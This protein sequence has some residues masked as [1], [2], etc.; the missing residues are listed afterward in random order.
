MKTKTCAICKKIKFLEEFHK[1]SSRKDNIHTDCKECR[2][3]YYILNK[4]KIKKYNKQYRDDNQEKYKNHNKEYYSK[5]KEKENQRV[6]K[7]RKNNR[8]KSRKYY[9]NYLMNRRENDII[10][11]ITCNLRN[12][13]RKVLKGNTKSLNTMFL[14]GCEIDYLMFHIQEQ[15]T[16]GMSW[17][18]YGDWHMDHIKPCSLFDLSKPDQQRKCFHFSNL[19]P[20]WAIENIRKGSKIL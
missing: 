15:F 14:I 10:F 11:K 6:K 3:N 12:R 17:D 2:K 5:N 8:K 1:N 16:S 7:W 18:N 13:I 20:L 9:K 19:Q 4:V